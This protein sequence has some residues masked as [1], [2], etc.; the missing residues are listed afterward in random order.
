MPTPREIIDTLL[1]QYEPRLRDAF[2]AA[3]EEIK[4]N[5]LLRIII[6][7]L[8]RGDVF[9]AVDAMQIDVGDFAMLDK[10]FADAYFGGGQATVD[11][12]PRVTGPD[13]NRVVFR[14]GVRNLEAEAF[15]REHSSTMVT[16]IVEDQREAIRQHLTSGLEAGRNPRQTALDVVGRVDRTSN[17]RTGGV[18]G[19]TAPQERFVTSARAELLSDDPAVV[20]RYFE[21]QRRDKRFDA[22]VRRAQKVGWEKAAEEVSERTGKRVTAKGLQDKAVGRYSDRLLALRGEMLSRTE[23]LT[24]LNRSRDDA[25]RQQIAEGKVDPQDV[26]KIWRSAHDA[27]VRLT[28]AVLDGKKAPFDGMFQSVSGAMLKH[29]GDPAAPASETVGC[30]CV[31]EY[32]IDFI[33]S[34]V[35]QRAA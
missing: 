29:P 26:T 28:H 13:G 34:V 33:G 15:L 9:G 5:I 22:L 16:R 18:I 1:A 20:E 23:T 21:R 31:V 6:E 12:L 11:N 17:R 27:R 10:A 8:E 25:I 19:L 4:S 14:F 2:L 32:K 3:I 24:A 7:R 30:R 35:R